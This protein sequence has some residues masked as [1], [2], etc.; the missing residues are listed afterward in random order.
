MERA[1]KFVWLVL[2]LPV[3]IVYL[4]ITTVILF[5]MAIIESIKDMTN[6]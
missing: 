1:L 2:F 6:G 4:I 3:R 5:A